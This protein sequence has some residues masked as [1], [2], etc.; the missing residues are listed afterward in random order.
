MKTDMPIVGALQEEAGKTFETG[1]DATRRMMDAAWKAFGF[2]QF[3]TQGWNMQN[4]NMQNWGQWNEKLTPAFQNTLEVCSETM[5]RQFRNQMDFVKRS[6]EMP[7]SQKPAD[8]TAMTESRV[9]DMFGTFRNSVEEAV[10]AGTR[11]MDCWTA[12]CDSKSEA[13][14]DTNGGKTARSAR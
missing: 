5:S 1:F 6:C 9:R 10:T 2:A 8:W 14:A 12:C 7:T 13:K 11:V 3:P 4:W